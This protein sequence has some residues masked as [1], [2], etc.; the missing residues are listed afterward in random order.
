ADDTTENAKKVFDE[1]GKRVT[2]ADKDSAEV[3]DNLAEV[4]IDRAETAFREGNS[5]ADVESAAS[6]LIKAYG[7]DE[8][9]GYSIRRYP[10]VIAKAQAMKEKYPDN[11]EVWL[12]QTDVDSLAKAGR[13]NADGMKAKIT[14]T[15][16]GKRYDSVKLLPEKQAQ[17]LRE[18]LDAGEKA[19][20][21]IDKG[22]GALSGGETTTSAK[23]QVKVR[24][25]TNAQ[26]F[27]VGKMPA[28]KPFGPKPEPEPAPKAETPKAEPTKRKEY[29]YEA[30]ARNEKI[31]SA[32]L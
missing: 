12:S 9:A 30:D 10:K 19:S 4:L 31:I 27:G 23:P 7:L 8:T 26:R 2:G 3:E 18:R 20:A 22:R 13:V 5:V 21:K 15:V 11:P 29:G 24:P 17:A 28:K 1:V 14:D 25:R 32:A 6:A 16:L